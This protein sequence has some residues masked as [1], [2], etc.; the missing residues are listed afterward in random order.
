M[1]W[2]SFC[3][4]PL[5]PAVPQTAGRASRGLQAPDRLVCEGAEGAAAVRDDFTVGRQLGEAPLELAQRDGARSLD[6][7]GRELLGR[8]H[9]DEH[10]IAA[11]EPL[12]QL[13][14]ADR[15]DLFA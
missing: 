10:D 2:I 7:S 4:L 13:L 9:V 1:R 11:A 6:V 12:D 14:A 3:Q 8:A 15:L 5:G